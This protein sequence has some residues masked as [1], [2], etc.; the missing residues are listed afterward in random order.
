M[1]YTKAQ[2]RAKLIVMLGGRAA[3]QLIYADYTTGAA[4]DLKRATALARQMIERFGMNDTIGPVAY[5]RD[6][7]VFVQ[8]I[9]RHSNPIEKGLKILRDCAAGLTSS[10]ETENSLSLSIG[11]FY[12]K[13][14]AETIPSDGQGSLIFPLLPKPVIPRSLHSQPLQGKELHVLRWRT[15]FR[16]SSLSSKRSGVWRSNDE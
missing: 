13:I 10:S 7:S 5:E 15:I 3:E 4:D 1:L 2:L 14:S 8:E 9:R 6:E 12:W 16:I 11:F